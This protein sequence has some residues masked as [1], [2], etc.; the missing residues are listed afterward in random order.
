MESKTS[1]DVLKE[2]ARLKEYFGEQFNQVFKSSTSDNS[3]KFTELSKIE[4]EVCV[5]VYFINP[6]TS[7]E[8]GTSERQNGML[9]CFSKGVAQ[10]NYLNIV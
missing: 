5:K 1:Y 7:C 3:Q 4:Q 10:E 9:R 2:F 8:R 6:Y